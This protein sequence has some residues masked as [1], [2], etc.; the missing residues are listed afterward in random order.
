MFNAASVAET[1]HTAKHFGFTFGDFTFDWNA[2]KN[3]RDA[4]ILRLNGIYAKNLAN[5]KVEIVSGTAS[6]IGPN[7]ITVDGKVKNQ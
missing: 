2:L 5:S 1:L 4:Y 6:F 7:Q 3:A